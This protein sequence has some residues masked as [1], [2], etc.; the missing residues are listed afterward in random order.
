M[1]L[2]DR[3]L[4]R[5]LL[6]PLA[7]C[8]AGFLI[9]WVTFDLFGKLEDFQERKL[10]IAQ[11]GEYYFLKTPELLIT[12]LPVAFL[13]ALLYALTTHARSN[14]IVAM[15]AAGMGLSRISLPY[16][17]VGVLFSGGLFLL[18]ET[19]V[20]RNMG[21]AEAILQGNKQEDDWVSNVNVRNA[22]ARRIWNIRRYHLKTGAM[23][24][25]QVEW[26]QADGSSLRVYAEVGA[27]TNGHWVFRNAE[28]RQ[29]TRYTPGQALSSAGRPI[30]TNEVAMRQFTETPQDIALHIKF[31][32]IDALEASKRVQ[33]R[34][35]E[36]KY[37]RENLELNQRDRALLDTQ[38]HAR[39]AEPWRCLV[40][41]FI[42]LP[43][44]T[45]TSRRNLFAG[46][47]SSIFICFFYFI[48]LR[49]GQ[50]LATGALIPAWVG[51]WL[52]NVLFTIGG[53]WAVLRSK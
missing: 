8:L 48:L 32:R 35:E 22:S 17:A 43:F 38:L 28:I 24:F 26:L 5:E 45:Y 49:I 30:F 29:H 2:L 1:R 50:G 11:I 53:L 51:A 10:G 40:V 46:V 44:G 27:W 14:E 6:V 7:Y 21:Q 25:P 37:L 9:F 41:V 42:A 23:E 36:I 20:S 18:N 19:V 12:V 4:L 39:L 52:P 34:L 16:V 15:R 31:R 13:L 33:L 3:Y 47:A